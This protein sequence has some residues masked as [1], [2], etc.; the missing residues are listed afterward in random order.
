MKYLPLL[1][2]LMTAC[3]SGKKSAPTASIEKQSVEV[4]TKISFDANKALEYTAKQVAFGPRVPGTTSH[5]ECADYMVETLKALG[6]KVEVQEFTAKGYDGTQ[7]EGKNII[8]SYLPEEK[9]RILLSAHWDSR[10]IADQDANKDK[11]LSPIDGAN[12]GASGVGVLMEV[13]R[14]LQIKAPNLG[15]DLI[16]FDVED[17]GAPS[18]AASAETEDSWCLGS[19]HWA[20]EAVENGYKARWGILLDM[21]GAGDAVF[22]KEQISLYYGKQLVDYVW[23]KAIS[24]GYGEYFVDQK[25]GMVTDDHLYV[26]QIAKIPCIDIIDFDDQRGGFNHTWHTHDDGIEN[27]DPNTLKAVGEVLMS[28]IYEQ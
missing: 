26:N 12:D 9:D 25:G 10:F 27:I 28:V 3:G 2:L 19:Q 6:A 24:M 17:Q 16:L 18:Y 13:A 23:D 21:V 15:I 1:L 5:S 8:A 22:M 7:W 11:Q 4:E 20:N 14:Q